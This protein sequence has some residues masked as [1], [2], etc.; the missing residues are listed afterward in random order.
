MVL[1][2]KTGRVHHYLSDLEYKFH[3]LSEFSPLVE[4]IRE[5]FALLPREETQQIA[6]SLNIVHPK[7][8][9]TSIPIVM[10][11][12]IV[13]T[14]KDGNSTKYAV[15]SIKPSSEL[16]PLKK[17]TYRVAEKL[18]IEKT[19]WENRGIPWKLLTD[20][21]ICDRRF[22]NLQLLRTSVA[23]RE[24]DWINECLP[25]FIESFKKHWN[26]SQP[27]LQ[28]LDIVSSKIGLNRYHCFMLFGRAVWSRSLPIDLDSSAIRHKLPVQF[29]R[30][31]IS[32]A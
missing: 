9:D 11:S 27:L 25:V 32:H 28:T 18:L 1:G 26:A 14:L 17:E 30:P 4:D 2:L 24:L 8:P 6:Q 3:V 19:Y 21:N 12:D 23:A 10:T 31:G 20:K 29:V 15:V 16:D 7:Y 5:Q 22:H 13:L